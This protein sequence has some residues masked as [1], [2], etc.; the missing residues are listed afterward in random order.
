[1]KK[2]FAGIL[3][4]LI[5]GLMV[6]T[7]AVALGNTPIKLIVNGNEVQCDVPPQNIGG[8]VLVPARFV[9]EAL[10]ATVEWDGATQSVIVKGKG[11]AG[12]SVTNPPAF[13][14]FPTVDNDIAMC[15][16]FT[17]NAQTVNVCLDILANP[18]ATVTEIDAKINETA[19]IM[20]EIDQWNPTSS[21]ERIQIDLYQLFKQT[22]LMMVEKKKIASGQIGVSA[23]LSNASFYVKKISE[24]LTAIEIDT[25]VLISQGLIR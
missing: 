7:C 4:G 18:N 14:W 19:A 20:N 13:N 3:M 6:S 21:F 1:M 8:R 16:K 24:Y 17:A 25:K 10:G 15:K 11:Y 12:P 22:N 9:A 23:G 5:V 2:F